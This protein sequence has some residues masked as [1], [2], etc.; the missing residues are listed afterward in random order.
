[1]L[2]ALGFTD[3]WMLGWLTAA[4]A[5]IIIHLW[6]KRKHREIEWAAMEYL[7]AAIRKN[8]RRIRIEQWLLLA[9]R[10]SIVVL[11]VLAVA[12]PYFQNFAGAFAV[13]EPTHKVLVIDGS[14][15]MDYRTNKTRFDRAKELAKQV[16][17][18]SSAA[19]GFTLVQLS[20]PPRVVIS[21]PVSAAGTIAEEIENLVMPHGGTDL[22]VAMAQV[23]EIVQ[24]AKTEKP[25]LAHAQVY[26]FTDLGNNTWKAADDAA[27]A[28]L[29]SMANLLIVDVGQS[30]TQNVAVNSLRC[31][32]P[33]AT[34]NRPLHFK[35]EIT[36][37]GRQP[38]KQNVQWWIDG[39][40]VRE[41]TIEVSAGR[42][43]AVGLEWKFDRAGQYSVEVRTPG[44][45]LEID[46]HRWLSLDVRPKV[47]VLIINGDGSQQATRQ[48]VSAM[49]PETDPAESPI[50]VDV[51]AESALAEHDISRYDA[52]FLSNVGQFT[53]AEAQML[54]RYVNGGGGLVIFLGDRVQP[55]RYNQELGGGREGSV[56]LLPAELE[57]PS[58]A[59]QF[60][61]DPL[62]Y[63]HAIVAEFAGNERSG[64]LTTPIAKYFRLKPL[65]GKESSA[66]AALTIRETGDPLIVEQSV[67]KGRVV[68]VALPASLATVDSTTKNPWTMMP[69]WHSFL[70]LVQEM[71][72]F[73]LGGQS[74]QHNLNVGDAL[75]GE[76]SASQGIAIT[77]PS[78]TDH[79]ESTRV[80]ADE[81]G[82]WHFDDTW[83]SG[84]Y[85]VQPAGNE[86][87]EVFAVNIET[88]DAASGESSL[89][90]IEV[91]E[92]PREFVLV[93]SGR[94]AGQRTSIDLNVH[95][96][97]ERWFLYA[98]LV[99]LLVETGYAGWLG[100]RAGG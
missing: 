9:I 33:Y 82:C 32:E 43:H 67:G 50:R 23:D 24:R 66:R 88:G 40:R 58:E 90:R 95:T 92:L 48:L 86:S 84:I 47:N 97:I 61:V 6:N 31:V 45:A 77:L 26:L 41:E 65:P 12:R 27:P 25:D 20:S 36:N 79:P 14:Y 72:A 80:A 62:G 30:Q 28:K 37:Y 8:S 87:A 81:E 85:R 83:N 99:L 34:A 42:Q 96:G 4:A 59:A 22:S 73:L 17:E 7:L 15:S 68:L 76:A 75:S 44:D 52:V 98:V 13:G 11:A 18:Q 93:N 89:Q 60:T 38:R 46:N 63:R 53:P 19:D 64:L 74:K 29:A 5:P 39:E 91:S 51:A 69:A 1:L 2:F 57:Q 10:T 54:S 21:S 55:E 56:R 3:F 94:S 71:L 49:N 78:I 35:A 70:P 100:R 16:I